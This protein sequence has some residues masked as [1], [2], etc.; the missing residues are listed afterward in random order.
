[1]HTYIQS[2]WGET[3]LFAACKCG[4]TDTAKVLLDHGASVHHRSKVSVCV[5]H[6]HTASGC[7]LFHVSPIDWTDGL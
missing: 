4:H 3:A 6:V 5:K 1:M 7:S 2:A